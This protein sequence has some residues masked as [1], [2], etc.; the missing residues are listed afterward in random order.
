M[1]VIFKFR[2]ASSGKNPKEEDGKKTS[3]AL[4]AKLMAR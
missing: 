2:P 1:T 4:I 3:A